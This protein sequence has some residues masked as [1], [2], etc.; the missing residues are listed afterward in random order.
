MV[1]Q[2][3][4]EQNC[5]QNFSQFFASRIMHE[6]IGENLQMCLLLEK[7][8]D[9]FQNFAMI[10]LAKKRKIENGKTAVTHLKWQIMI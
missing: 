6:K 5:V 8:P 1:A 10:S 7:N 4:H 2:F 3:K 9:L